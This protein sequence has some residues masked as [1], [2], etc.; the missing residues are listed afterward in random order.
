MVAWVRH[1]SGGTL[2][3]DLCDE[4]GNVC[5][6]LR[7]MSLGA[8][9][10][11]I[12]PAQEASR[13]LF[14][15]ECWQEQFSTG[16]ALQMGDAKIIIFADSDTRD[17]IV[18]SDDT[19]RFSEASFVYQAE[20]Y[21]KLSAREYH[22]RFGAGRDIQELLDDATAAADNREAAQPVTIVFKWATGKQA[23]GIHALFDLFKVIRSSAHRVTHVVLVGR[24]DPSRVE[25]SWDYS[26]V[27]FERSLKHLLPDTRITVLYT[28][29]G[30]CDAQQLC[31][32]MHD[33]G[34]LW[35]RDGRRLV[36]SFEPVE[37]AQTSETT[38]LKPGGTYLI[39]GGC[40]ALGLKFALH[41]AE[42]CRAKLLL[43]GRR[44]SSPGIEEHLQRLIEAGAQE[45]SYHAVDVSDSSALLS[46]AQGLSDPISGIIHAAGVESSSPFFERTAA[47][48]DSVLRPK[49][50]G[51]LALDEVFG[52]RP[53]DFI[54]YFSS[55]AASF[56][57]HGACDYA[58]ANRFQMGYG[59]HRQQSAPG[60]TIVINWPFWEQGGMGFKD[61]EQTSRYLKMSA[62]DFGNEPLPTQAGLDLWRAIMESGQSQT[63]VI[64]GKPMQVATF[65]RRIHEGRERNERYRYSNKV[66]EVYSLIL[67][68]VTSQM[69]YLTFCP[70]E[71]I[72]AGFSMSATYLNPRRHAAEHHY[73]HLKQTEMRQV[74]FRHED[75][76]KLE[77]VF[78]IGC[79]HG[80]DV[81]QMAML[82]PHLQVH[83]FTISGEQARLGN[84][85]ISSRGLASRIFHKDSAKDVFPTRYDL[86]FGIEVCPHIEDKEGLFANIHNSLNK[87]GTVLLADVLSNQPVSAADR[88]IG[89]NIPTREEW[90][91]VMCQFGLRIDEFVDVSPQIANFLHDPQVQDNV[92]NLPEAIR[93]TY[94]GYADLSTALDEG[95][96]SYVLV[97]LKV[98][99]GWSAE[100]LAVHNRES[101]SNPMPYAT[102]LRAMLKQPRVDYPAPVEESAPDPKCREAEGSDA[103]NTEWMASGALPA[104]RPQMQ[105]DLRNSLAVVLHVKASDIDPDQPFSE[106][107]L[108]SF[109]GVEWVNAINAEY[110]LTLPNIVVYDYPS[111][112]A[113][114]SFLE[115]ET[116]GVPA[117]SRR[118]SLPDTD[119]IRPGPARNKKTRTGRARRGWTAGHEKVA[120]I[121]MS[122]RYP[123]AGNLRKYWENLADGENAIVEI[124]PARWDV[125]R[126]YDPDPRKEDKTCSKWLGALDDIDCFDPLFFRIAPRDAVEMDPQQRLFLEESYR[127]FEDAGYSGRVSNEKCGV[128][129]GISTTEYAHRLLRSGVRAAPVTSI[130][131]AIAAA[132]IAYY[133]NLK[134]P[135]ISL[136][137][138]CSSSLVALHL[139]CQGLWN[140]ET[141]LALS[142]GVSLWLAPESYLSMSRAGMLSPSGQCKTFD[143]AAD[144]IV[145][146]EG[147][148]ALVLKRL[149]DAEDDND[150]IYGIILG[151]GINQDG[152][153]NGITAPSVHSQADL[154]REVYSRYGIDPETI[155]Y[156]ETH[157]TGTKLGDPIELTA[158]SAVFR[159]RTAKTNYCAVASVKSNIGHTAAAAGVASVQKVLLSLKHRTLVPSLNVRKENSQFD[160][161]S[162]P[163]YISRESRAWD[164]VPGSARRAAVSSFGF[165]GTN[166]HLVIEEYS[167]PAARPG[168]DAAVIIPLSARTVEQ[169]RQRSQDLLEFI[170]TAE[171]PVDLASVAYTLQTGREAMEERLGVAASSV[172]QLA[173]TLDAYARG[174]VNSEDVH[175]GRVESGDEDMPSFRRDDDMRDAVGSW[176]AERKS[177]KVLKLWTQGLHFDWNRLYGDVKPRRTSLPG[178]PFARERYWIDETPV[179]RGADDKSE[180]ARNTKLIED[181]INRIGD[182]AI[183]TDDAVRLL[184][185]LV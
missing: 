52:D 134:G 123:Q 63:L 9:P 25:T 2:D 131:S 64:V 45:A 115:K 183:R 120:I 105:D 76:R 151:S 85:R 8:S 93:A 32:A 44:Q 125:R 51:T 161:K 17:T 89:M 30:D 65:L 109:L 102:A 11:P 20:S 112:N 119:R 81:I 1:V 185:A 179:S 139:A 69:E 26:W 57:D 182:D 42:T 178:Y 180:V 23:T 47:D 124:P 116:R 75:F 5:V 66:E 113:L 49:T 163:F 98:N 121:G 100:Q 150:F 33:G 82:F 68:S 137:T 18:H 56:G 41:L 21:R 36:L 86:I 71:S 117:V 129:L 79:G 164:V 13:P 153:T 135:A 145:V 78:D 148:G 61:H 149:K 154:I 155:S 104:N 171:Q 12:A 173:E 157:G 142:G 60:R 136:D 27:G 34:V 28:E 156:V 4:Q 14:F 162:S 128:Y 62:Q 90:L 177:S 39:T 147:V 111:L 10:D 3:I 101:M 133:L 37:P 80:T 181:V 108:D 146:G 174:E 168:D 46:W 88:A 167:S 118:P 50:L 58:V 169:L 43:L 103:A 97:R 143:D 176:I 22:C 92:R 77:S 54:C 70:F 24:Y 91:R 130:S 110:G 29:S 126:Y 159:E 138:A 38:F 165:S 106:L 144:G 152:R 140:R 15:R 40:G 160:F 6:Q 170:R 107:G 114:T 67:P 7:R 175:C 19:C 84:Q 122:G 48:I 94:V 99:Q 132:R 96:A 83:G 73:V 35:Y 172:A 59:I 127:A 31:E 158:L 16:T 184:K 72:R 55:T 53:L 166:A 87:D 141:D 74:L 95:L